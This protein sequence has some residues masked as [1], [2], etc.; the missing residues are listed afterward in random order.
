MNS[1]VCWYVSA[2]ENGL[3]MINI[4]KLDFIPHACCW[5]HRKGIAQGLLAM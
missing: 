2:N 5:V 3:D 1:G 4:I